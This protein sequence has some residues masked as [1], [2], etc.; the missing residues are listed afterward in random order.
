MNTR[1]IVNGAMGKM[2]ALACDTIKKHA[3]FDLVGQL[4]RRD[5]L[6]IAIK[7]TKA[8]IVLE[9]TR[10]D[11]VYDNSLTIIQQGARPVIG[12]SG[13][14]KPQIETLCALCHDKNIGGIIAPNFSLGVIVMMRC[15]ALAAEFFP[16][17]EIIEAH[18]QQKFDAPS[19]TA[20]K[21]AELIDE[22]R[23][24]PKSTALQKE[25]IAGVRGGIYHNIPIHSLR[26][27]GILANQQIIFGSAGET[28]TLSH[29]SLDRGCFMPGIVLAC[30]K[31]MHLNKMVYGL[32]HVIA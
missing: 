27:P 32:E 29:N 9:L 31:V 30:E 26:L 13:L 28:L 23:T 19:G 8:D 14:T 20:L 25:S 16:E 21:T 15:A 6:A 1:I 7:E 18:H 10:A 24:Q 3:A 5:D 4:T 17:V 11:C 2:G 12:A 22:A